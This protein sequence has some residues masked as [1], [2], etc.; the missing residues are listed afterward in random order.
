MRMTV[1]NILNYFETLNTSKGLGIENFYIGK[2]DNKKDKSIG[3]YNL[4]AGKENEVIGGL[5]NKSDN[6]LNVSI[7]IH[8]TKKFRETDNFSNLF[9][10]TLLKLQDENTVDNPLI[11]DGFK[12]NYIEMLSNNVDIGTDENGIYERTIN[13]RINYCKEI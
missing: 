8:W 2:L 5:D 3:F 1:E 4:R 6:E 9:F 11:I 13:I 12:V 10:D 7:L